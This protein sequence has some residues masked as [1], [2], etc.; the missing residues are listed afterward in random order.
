MDGELR[1]PGPSQS[2]SN[3]NVAGV[4]WVIV[5]R[6]GSLVSMYIWAASMKRISGDRVMELCRSL[7]RFVGQTFVGDLALDC[8]CPN[9]IAMQCT[10]VDACEYGHCCGL[11]Q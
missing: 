1:R 8:R 4:E 6:T 7:A 11:V 5:G 10:P 9:A 3:S 2:T